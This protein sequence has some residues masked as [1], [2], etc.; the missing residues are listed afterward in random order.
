MPSPPHHR[1]WVV[2]FARALLVVCTLARDGSLLFRARGAARAV[3]LQTGT[4]ARKLRR[5]SQPDRRDGGLRPFSLWR[6][7]DRRPWSCRRSRTGRD[8]RRPGSPWASRGGAAR[9][10]RGTRGAVRR[11]LAG[12]PGRPGSTA[13][14]PPP[15][16]APPPCWSSP[17]RCAEEVDVPRL[18]LLTVV[19]ARLSVSAARSCFTS[20]LLFGTLHLVQ[21]PTPPSNRYWVASSLAGIFLRRMCASPCAA[22]TPHGWRISRWNWCDGR[23]GGTRR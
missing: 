8:L 18:I 5:L 11:T 3:L 16:C 2:A 17:P 21:T 13:V 22:C 1:S 23:A 7:I 12:L 15:R 4:A 14:D 20:A 9:D 6:L 10:Q 19:P